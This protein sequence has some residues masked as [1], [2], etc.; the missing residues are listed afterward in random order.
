M[1]KLPATIGEVKPGVHNSHTKV[2][3]GGDMGG[4]RKDLG[5]EIRAVREGL[6]GKVTQPAFAEMLGYKPRAVTVS[7][8]ERNESRPNRETLERIAELAG[9][10]YEEF[11]EG[12]DTGPT[13]RAEPD[14]GTPSLDQLSWLPRLVE[15]VLDDNSLSGAEKRELVAELN[16]SA[17]RF[18]AVAA[19]WASG[20]R[21]IAMTQAEIASGARAHTNGQEAKSA[22]VRALTLK[23][24]GEVAPPLSEEE[25]IA[26]AEDA[27]TSDVGGEHAERKRAGGE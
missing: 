18:W 15:K 3:Q 14:E 12:V 27:P 9:K 24:R 6:P 26:A 23:E 5:N 16:A 7:D 2:Y 4:R 25:A 20:Q 1:H 8:W 10:S 22:S 21:G 13:D 19:E 11:M 17:M